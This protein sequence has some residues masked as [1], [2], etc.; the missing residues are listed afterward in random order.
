MKICYLPLQQAINQIH[1]PEGNQLAMA[2]NQDF[3][4]MQKKFEIYKWLSLIDPSTHWS[5]WKDFS[6]YPHEILSTEQD[7]KEKISTQGYSAIPK[8]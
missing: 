7:E 5:D 2:I 3:L 6:W 1:F 8:F 4:C